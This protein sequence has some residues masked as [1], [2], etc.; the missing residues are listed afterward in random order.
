MKS[1]FIDTWG[2]TPVDIDPDCT[3]L[4]F[5]DKVHIVIGDQSDPAF[6]DD[7]FKNNNTYF[8]IVID[9]GGHMMQQ[10]I[11][12]FEKVYSR[13]NYGGVYLCEDRQHTSYWDEFGGGYL[14]NSSFIVYH[15]QKPH[16]LPFDLR[17]DTFSVS[18]YDSIV[19]LEKYLERD[20]KNP[21]NLIMN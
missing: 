12:T 3:L 9:D 2:K 4:Q 10:Q 6:W 17:K 13:L 21:F 19:V 15:V 14:K 7:F 5:D 16:S 18:F 11:I 8:D 20:E 1:I